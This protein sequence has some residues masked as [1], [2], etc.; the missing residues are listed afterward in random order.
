MCAFLQLL[1]NCEQPSLMLFSFSDQRSKA[2]TTMF[3]STLQRRHRAAL[4]F[5]GKI[6][7]CVLKQKVGLSR[8]K[9]FNC[10]E[11]YLG[12]RFTQRK[13]KYKFKTSDMEH[14]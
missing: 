4:M 10:L 13:E 11:M 12:C 3:L 14:L 6:M 7:M 1:F 9:L 8:V 2:R 5:E